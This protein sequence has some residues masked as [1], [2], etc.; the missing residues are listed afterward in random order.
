MRL[1]RTGSSPI[2][3]ASLLALALTLTA[4]PAPA[5]AASGC[6]ASKQKDAGK[7]A[8]CLTDK[9]AKAIAKRKKSGVARSYASCERKLARSFEAIEEASG[10]ECPLSGDA[11]LNRVAFRSCV[12]EVLNGLLGDRPVPGRGKKSAKCDAKKAK[13]AGRYLQCQQRLAAKESDGTAITDEEQAECAD[14][15]ARRLRR[16]EKRRCT[17]TGDAAL[18]QAGL[19]RC[20]EALDPALS[21]LE[22]TVVVVDRYPDG[23]PRQLGIAIEPTAESAWIIDGLET[24]YFAD[25]ALARELVDDVG[26][27]ARIRGIVRVGIEFLRTL[28][29]RSVELSDE[30]RVWPAPD[31]GVASESIEGAIVVLERFESGHPRLLGVEPDGGPAV[32]FEVTNKSQ[33]LVYRIGRRMRVDGVLRRDGTLAVVSYAG[34]EGSPVV[35]SGDGFRMSFLAGGLDEAGLLMGGVEIDALI[36]FDGRIFAGSS[37]RKNTMEETPD[38]DVVSQVLLLDRPDG[39]WKVD[40]AVPTEVAG[41]A[42][43]IAFLTIV[44]FEADATGTP[45]AAPVE[46]LAA[47]SGSGE[48]YLRSAG[49]PAQWV[50]T[51]LREVIQAASMNSPRDPDARSAVSHT[52]RVTGV[53][54]LFAGGGVG[55]RGAGGGIYR[56]AYDPSRPGLIAWAT[57]AEVSIPDAPPN[58]RVMGLSEV[59]GAVY[60]ALGTSLLRREDGPSPSWTEVYRDEL[61]AGN[62]SIRRAT[63]VRAPDGSAALLFGIE[64]VSSRVVRVDPASGDAASEE[65]SVVASVPG[66]LYGAVAY[67][68]PETRRLDGGGELPILGSTL[69]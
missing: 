61:P 24:V 3:S 41:N 53:S 26:R 12:D 56:G 47:V 44:R 29:L 49:E 9:A 20:A 68:G 66:A 8:K 31:P 19:D 51:E 21:T 18:I 36:A 42:P 46:M 34:L 59:N 40:F 60:A 23:Q 65:Y 43:R 25:G 33:E 63:E 57:E 67:N 48:I 16:A 15:L 69:R 38:P 30:I 58:P 62:D 54:Y 7:Y 52:D 4:A 55:R 2:L 17:V 64:G 50:S 32:A 27:R 5:S 45:L 28:H 13:A 22:G 6:Q 1:F 14:K 39:R 35:S 10:L 11:A 37:Y